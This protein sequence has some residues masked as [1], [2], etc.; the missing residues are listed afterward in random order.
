MRHPRTSWRGGRNQGLE[1]AGGGGGGGARNEINSHL[2]HER[3][4]VESETRLW[5]TGGK[6]EGWGPRS[7]AVGHPCRF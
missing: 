3:V 4:E 5:W 2:P 1:D 6:A 7:S